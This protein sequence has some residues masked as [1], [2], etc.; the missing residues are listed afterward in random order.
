MSN[1][2]AAE[3]PSPL[4]FPPTSPSS[5][6]LQDDSGKEDG[7]EEKDSVLLIGKRQEMTEHSGLGEA[8]WNL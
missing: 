1:V 5:Y 3:T 2:P 4:P 8:C 7:K 6:R